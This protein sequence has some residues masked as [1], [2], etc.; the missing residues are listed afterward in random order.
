MRINS[1]LKRWIGTWVA[2]LVVLP[3]LVLLFLGALK[4][5]FD[6]RLIALALPALIYLSIPGMLLKEPHFARQEWGFWLPSTII[7]CLLQIAL[8]AALA[9]LLG[10]ISYRITAKRNG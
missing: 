8:P 10:W 1:D 2:V 5:F 4:Y 7:G 3:W 6:S 9:A